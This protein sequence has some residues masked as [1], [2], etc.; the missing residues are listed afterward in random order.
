MTDP[1]PRAFAAR[2]ARLLA[3]LS[4]A[5]LALGLLRLFDPLPLGTDGAMPVAWLA[6]GVAAALAVAGAAAALVA[7]VPAL[8]GDGSVSHALDAAAAGSV[9]AAAGMVALSGPAASS[10]LPSLGLAA[11]LLAAALPLLTAS[12]VGAVALSSRRRRAVATVAVFA[13]IEVAPLAGILT[14]GAPAAVS[15]TAGAAA[16]LLVVTAGAQ[17]VAGNLPRAG[18]MLGLATSAAV[19]AAARPGSADALPGLATAGAALVAMAIA[20]GAD[21]GARP[22]PAAPA[23]AAGAEIDAAVARGTEAAAESDRLARELRGTIAELIASHET[24]RL[25]REELERLAE[26]DPVTRV[27]TRQT[28]LARLHLEA[29]EAR[30]YAHPIAVVLIDLDGLCELNARHGLEIGDAILGEL[31]LRLRMRIREADTIG[32]L[33]GDT[34]LAILPHTDERGAAIFADAIRDRLTARPVLTNAGSVQMT[35]S[36]GITVARAGVTDGDDHELLARA[37]E[38][39]SSARAAGGNRIAFDREHGLARLDGR[40]RGAAGAEAASPETAPDEGHP[41]S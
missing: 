6:P 40:R 21:R 7:L 31:A 20:D 38:A 26:V 5:P 37:E 2:T 39:L 30:R 28:V 16:L 9:A 15:A 8:Q 36:I 12:L 41:G 27:A 23:E 24:V 32:R 4:L 14:G 18:W 34:F 35:V 11:A 10:A 33:S 29:A 3:W 17:V 25:Q 1:S 19:L 22:L 13:W